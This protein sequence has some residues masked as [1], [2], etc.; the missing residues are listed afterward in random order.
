[1]PV[2]QKNYVELINQ[3]NYTIQQ[4]HLELILVW[5]KDDLLFQNEDCCCLKI[6][7]LE[8]IK[9]YN[10]KFRGHDQETDVLAFSCQIP[11]VFFK[12][13]IIICPEVAQKD[14]HDTT[15]N[16]RIQELF[17]HGLLHL[18]GMDHLAHQAKKLMDK[19]EIK[20][21]KK[22]QKEKIN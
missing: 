12:G 18:C 14:L 16:Y 22:L 15:L 19:Y 8:E 20:Y 21:R 7:D 3:T 10:H 9:N 2:P 17:I 1:M 6:S 4:E 11:N 13:D 5:M